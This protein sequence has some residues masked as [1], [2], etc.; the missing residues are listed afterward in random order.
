MTSRAGPVRDLATFAVALRGRGLVVT[1]D[2][3]SDMARAITLVDASSRDQV[4]ASLRALTITGPEQ[5]EPFD[6]EFERFF[7]PRAEPVPPAGEQS[8]LT[9]LSAVKPIVER[10]G[11][12][13]GSDTRTQAGASATENLSSRDFADLDEDQLS[14]A[15]RLVMA[16]TWQPT[17]VRTRRWSLSKSG[18]TPDL[19]RTLRGSTRPE[20]DL[21]PIMRRERRKRQRPLIIIADISGSMEK[22]ADL[23]L[24]FAHA[25]QHRVDSVEVFT[26]STELTR[27]T[28]DLRRRDTR[29]A[30]AR[31]SVKVHDWSGGTKIGD[32]LAE[33]NQRW[34][35]RLSRGGPIVMILSDGWDCGDPGL[36]RTEMARLSR[37]VHKVIWLNPLAS[38]PDY[39]PA[40][41]G[42]RA[43]LPYVDH[44]LPAASVNDLRGVVRLLDALAR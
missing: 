27:V 36:L 11:E 31:V 41:R 40:T 35:R 1:P 37:S 14:A 10:L 28:E 18:G 8:H 42:M 19:R 43:V 5:R 4:F 29:S 25:A 22:Y 44:L 38:R 9:A 2:Q 6:E 39:R 23:F 26:F 32:A 33:W 30:L 12:M 24:V 20:G 3:V 13:P 21:M 17:D 34:S 15:R 16:M 7:H